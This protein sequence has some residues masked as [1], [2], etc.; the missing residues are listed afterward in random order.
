M[1][2]SEPRSL[3]SRAIGA[4]ISV[5]VGAATLYLAVRLIESVAVALCIMA[6]AVVLVGVVVV[7]VRHRGR[8][9]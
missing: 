4:C 3:L 6:G 7:F 8:G 2:S 9:W 5:L 1:W